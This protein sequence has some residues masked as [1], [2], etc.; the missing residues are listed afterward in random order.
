MLQKRLAIDSSNNRPCARCKKHHF[1]YSLY[2][3]FFLSLSLCS[4]FVAGGGGAAGAGGAVFVVAVMLLSLLLL[5]LLLL[6]S[7]LLLLL[8]LL[9][10]W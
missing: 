5:L 4:D 9:R 2:Y 7:L 1:I 10:G 8:L 3:S 6:L